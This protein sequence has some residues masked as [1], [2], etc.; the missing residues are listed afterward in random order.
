MRY[1]SMGMVLLLC[2]WNTIPFVGNVIGAG[3]LS[4][5]ISAMR[6]KQRGGGTRRD[7]KRKI[8]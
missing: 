8:Q 7:A 1:I 6:E 2:L 4:S 5:F 3:H